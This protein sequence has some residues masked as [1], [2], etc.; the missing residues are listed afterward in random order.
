[1]SRCY[2]MLHYICMPRKPIFIQWPWSRKRRRGQLDGSSSCQPACMTTCWQLLPRNSSR[3]SR[4]YWNVGFAR[5]RWPGAGL[6]RGAYVMRRVKEK[7]ETKQNLEVL[8]V[9]P[10]RVPRAPSPSPS[11]T[12][13]TST[14]GPAKLPRIPRHTEQL[15]L[16]FDQVVD[17]EEA[18]RTVKDL[19][20]FAEDCIGRVF[21]AI[22][23]FSVC[24]ETILPAV[25]SRRRSSSM[26]PQ[27][28]MSKVP[29]RRY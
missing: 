5:P 18:L 12:L 29:L 20:N 28:S 27:P 23:A 11:P 15:P 9:P 1:M 3:N 24:W 7:P 14:T 19:C 10:A 4:P 17:I 25:R 6:A 22:P 21:R 13:A 26:W 2:W 8:P 16:T